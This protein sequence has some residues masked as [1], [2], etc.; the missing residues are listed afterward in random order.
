MRWICGLTSTGRTIGGRHATRAHDKVDLVE[1]LLEAYPRTEDIEVMLALELNETLE[2]IALLDPSLGREPLRQLELS[3][4]S[5]LSADT[6][7]QPENAV[8]LLVLKDRLVSRLD[9]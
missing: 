1:S 5:H 3:L 9:L 2:A 4:V 7:E 8:V 6:V